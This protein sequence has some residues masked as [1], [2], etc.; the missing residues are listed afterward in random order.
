M[1]R[2]TVGLETVLSLLEPPM[3]TTFKVVFWSIATLLFFSHTG[4]AQEKK[5][6]PNIVFILA[7]D[8]GVFDL[9]CYGRK[10]HATPNLNRLAKQGVRFTNAYAAQPLCS[11][12]RAAILT[13]KSPARLRITTFLPGRANAP[14]QM[15]NSPIIN[16]QLPGAEITLASRLR[17]LGY[18]SA[19]IGKWHL[20]G[21][22]SLPT[23]HGFDMYYAGTA[24]TE[25]S[26]TEGG[27]GEYDLTNQAVKFIEKNKDRPFFLHLCHNNPHIALH[28]KP[29]LIEKHKAAFNPTYAAMIETLDDTVGRVLAKLDELGL[30][31]NTI[32]I[33]TSDNGGLH[34]LEGAITP[35]THNGIFRS[36]KGFLYEGG[37]RIPLIVRWPGHIP[38]GK[39]I[40]T[41]VIST[42]WTPTFLELA[43]GKAK[44][45]FD[46]VSLVSLLTK[47]AALEDR[48]LCWH[49]PHYSNQGSRPSGAIR[50]KN[51]KLIE[52]Y[53]SGVCE[54]FDLDRDPGEATDLAAKQPARVAELRGKLE[55]WRRDMD[56][57]EMTA[58]PHFSSNLWKAA[59]VENDPSRFPLLEPASL[60]EKQQRGWRGVMNEALKKKHPGGAGAVVLHARD[61]VVTGGKLRYE[62]EPHKDTLGF[63][64]NASDSA[65]WKCKIPSK[66][67]FEVEVL[68]AC[69]K[70]SGGSEVE[71]VIAGQ[72]LTFKV[73]ET[74]HFQYFI[75]RTIGTIEINEPGEVRVSV[76]ARTKPG[77]AVMD[78]RRIVLKSA[79]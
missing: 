46:G 71:V 29:K 76:K 47:G 53:D 38:A 54:L 25:P 14:S 16:Q 6:P 59:Y 11:P 55:K 19:L 35:A 17:G 51:W 9:N 15:L 79:S 27:K 67:R 43:G 2:V 73:E 77:A 45:S 23:D 3:R 61:A 66:G 75:P 60:M 65:E 69:G 32:V 33:F 8:L 56:A 20:G 37:V 7:D 34:V 22:G 50:D 58:N 40:P 57:Q 36:G 21:K 4:L 24:K 1:N 18:I 78:L 5:R 63:W 64:V 13:G 72:K 28:A 49:F 52:H 44:E 39:E 68:Q 62:R 26:D 70:G 30:A 41:P 12:T 42:D 48:I 74:G 31:E 10:E